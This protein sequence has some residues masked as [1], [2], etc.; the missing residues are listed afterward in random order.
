[1][2]KQFEPRILE[3]FIPVTQELYRLP[4]CNNPH[5]SG[6][7]NEKT[8]IEEAAER[9]TVLRTDLPWPW[10]T[11]APAQQDLPLA[12]H[13]CNKNSRQQNLTSRKISIGRG[14]WCTQ[15]TGVHSWQ[16]L[17]MKRASGPAHSTKTATERRGK[18]LGSRESWNKSCAANGPHERLLTRGK[19]IGAGAICAAREAKTEE[20]SGGT[21]NDRLRTAAAGLPIKTSQ[22][23]EKRRE[24]EITGPM[25]RAVRRK[26]E[27]GTGISGKPEADRALEITAVA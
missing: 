22:V 25:D 20:N 27:S 15:K 10:A 2:G 19:E 24:P 16:T 17:K 14:N 23:E 21:E 8:D 9:K 6:N 11:T 18:V 7:Q 4:P 12:L 5:Q 26:N 1:V 13:L 3:S